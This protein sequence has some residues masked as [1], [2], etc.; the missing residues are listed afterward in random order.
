MTTLRF[1]LT[2][3]FGCGNGSTMATNVFLGLVLVVRV[4]IRF[5]IP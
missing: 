2:G 4:V 3:H 1:C 5:L